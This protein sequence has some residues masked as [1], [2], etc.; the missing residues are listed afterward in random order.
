M[1]IYLDMCCL[2]RPFDDKTQVRVLV[3]AEAVL[4]VA[5][6]VRVGQT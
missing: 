1:K 4:G 2:Q 6:F 5:C 3:E